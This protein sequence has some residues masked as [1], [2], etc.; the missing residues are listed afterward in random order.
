MLN[1]KVLE[2]KKAIEEGISEADI[3]IN[4]NALKSGMKDYVIHEVKTLQDIARENNIT[5][6]VI[7]EVGLLLESEIKELVEDLCRIG[8]DYIKTS[9]GFIGRGVTVNDIMLLRQIVKDRVKIKAAGGVRDAK[10]A[11]ALILAGASRIGTSTGVE[12]LKGYK[13]L[14][15]KLA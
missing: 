11:V 5:L 2:L 4:L 13:A 10:F 8:V 12:I 14:R 3:V 1:V 9:T 6:K 15:E 7:I